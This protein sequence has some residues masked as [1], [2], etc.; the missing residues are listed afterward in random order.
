VLD[1]VSLRLLIAVI[2]VLT[3]VPLRLDEVLHAELVSTESDR[4]AVRDVHAYDELEIADR[5]VL[6]AQILALELR[7]HLSLHVVV[8]A[9]SVLR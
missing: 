4:V 6:R 5:R 3:I 2:L 1:V 8:F 9:Y 7:S